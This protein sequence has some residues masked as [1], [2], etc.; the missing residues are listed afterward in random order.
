MEHLIEMDN[1]YKYNIF[2]EYVPHAEGIFLVRQS[3]F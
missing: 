1:L 2:L 3:N